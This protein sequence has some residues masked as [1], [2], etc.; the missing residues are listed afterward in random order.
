MDTK[1]IGI[2]L[3]TKTGWAVL[4]ADGARVASGTWVLSRRGASAEWPVVELRR[5]LIEL[6]QAFP[7]AVIRYEEV[8]RHAGTQ[9]AHMY[10]ALRMALFEAC[11]GTPYAGIPVGTIKAT[12]TGKGNANKEAMI[13]AANRRWAPHVVIDDNES[14]ALWIA[15]CGRLGVA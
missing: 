12:A 14:D 2:D 6:Q 10:G 11:K 8:A 9:A 3:A 1:T 13:E 15:E 4:D 5:K 7:G